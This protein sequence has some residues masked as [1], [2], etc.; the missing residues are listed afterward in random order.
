MSSPADKRGTWHKESL[1]TPAFAQAHFGKCEHP[2]VGV[3][4][5]E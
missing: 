4:K 2:G 1:R 5:P 3:W